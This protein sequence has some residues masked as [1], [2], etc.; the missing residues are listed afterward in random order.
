ML[1][2][3][4]NAH[5]QIRKNCRRKS[6]ALAYI[7]T[8]THIY[9]YTD[10]RVTSSALVEST[11][12]FQTAR[13]CVGLSSCYGFLHTRKHA[14]LCVCACVCAKLFSLKLHSNFASNFLP[15]PLATLFVIQFASKYYF[16]FHFVISSYVAFDLLHSRYVGVACH[17]CLFGLFAIQYSKCSSKTLQARLAS[18]MHDTMCNKLHFPAARGH[19]LHNVALRFVGSRK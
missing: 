15:F 13:V 7:E 9:V 18:H 4:A 8:H 5:K 3:R 17:L 2:T 16:L 1:G 12:Q 14:W 19:L 6:C 10:A 11:V